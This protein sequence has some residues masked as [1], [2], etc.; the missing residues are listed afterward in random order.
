MVLLF[1]IYLN[2]LIGWYELS[3]KPDGKSPF[4]IVGWAISK[5]EIPTVE[6]S[7]DEKLYW[8]GKPFFEYPTIKEKYPGFLNS[9]KAGFWV[10]IDVFKFSQGKHKINVFIFDNKEKIFLGENYFERKAV[11]PLYMFFGKNF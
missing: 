11:T 5:N 1:F 10:F 4:A 9:E 7:I 8:K 2:N 3:P 6:I